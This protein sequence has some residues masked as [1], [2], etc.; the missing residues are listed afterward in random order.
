[1]IIDRLKELL[2]E[3]FEMDAETITAD[4]DIMTDLGADSLDVVEF[5]MM[6]EEEFDINISDEH[7]YESKTVG[8]IADYIESL[9]G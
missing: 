2:A 5:I 7:S 1:M 3:Q 6:I 4:T 8:E 9:L